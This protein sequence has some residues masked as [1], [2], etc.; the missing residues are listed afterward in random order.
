MIGFG[1]IYGPKPYKFI[2]FADIHGP[3]SGLYKHKSLPDGAQELRDRDR[4]W[5]GKDGEKQQLEHLE[6]EG[7]RGLRRWISRLGP[8]APGTCPEY[9]PR[10]DT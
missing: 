8:G 10:R 9:W 1:D 7:P 2:G 4:T 5:Q 6:S 3:H